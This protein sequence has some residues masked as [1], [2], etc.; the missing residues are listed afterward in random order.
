[1]RLVSCLLLLLLR[2]TLPPRRV[3]RVQCPAE[4]VQGPVRL[5]QLA[6]HCPC[7]LQ[8][9]PLLFSQEHQVTENSRRQTSRATE[10]SL[11]PESSGLAD[12]ILTPTTPPH[13][14]PAR[15]VTEER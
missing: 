5:L 8:H 13:R 9:P 2:I 15:S 14:D 7:A 12:R 11:A 10:P 4:G 3:K 6:E 1:M